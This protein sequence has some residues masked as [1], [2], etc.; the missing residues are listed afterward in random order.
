MA[1]ILDRLRLAD[2]MHL[3]RFL[4]D[5]S[6]KDASKFKD[7]FI[8]TETLPINWDAHP[9]NRLRLENAVANK[10]LKSDCF[11]IYRGFIFPINSD[12]KLMNKTHIEYSLGLA[13]SLRLVFCCVP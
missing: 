3:Y 7:S 11:C 10:V 6:I 1:G 13:G 8:L 9:S 5:G 4:E 2:Q 12:P